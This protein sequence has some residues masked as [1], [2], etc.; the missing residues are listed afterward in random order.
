MEKLE[1]GNSFSIRFVFY[2]IRYSEPTTVNRTTSLIY[3]IAAILAPQN[4]G[5]KQ[6]GGYNESKRN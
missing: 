4:V 5:K 6:K 3:M 1:T 2:K